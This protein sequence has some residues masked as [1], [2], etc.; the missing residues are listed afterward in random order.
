MFSACWHLCIEL[1][2]IKLLQSSLHVCDV[3]TAH[4]N[5]TNMSG[6]SVESFTC[7]QQMQMYTHV[8]VN[9]IKYRNNNLTLVGKEYL[10]SLTFSRGKNLNSLPRVL[11]QQSCHCY[12]LLCDCDRKFSLLWITVYPYRSIAGHSNL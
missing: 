1:S 6:V 12:Q 7:L 5:T 11:V 4:K 8:V 9:F 3:F 2:C 10:A